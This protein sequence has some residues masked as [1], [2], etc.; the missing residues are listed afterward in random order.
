MR[1]HS[2]N[3]SISD[4]TTSD[5]TLTC[6]YVTKLLVVPSKPSGDYH[7]QVVVRGQ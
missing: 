1:G 6:N 5:L 2:Q 3:I 7:S 4:L